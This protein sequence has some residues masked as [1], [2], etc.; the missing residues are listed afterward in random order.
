MKNSDHKNYKLVEKRYITEIKSDVYHFVHDQTNASI[1]Y[2]SNDDIDKFMSI[3]F[4]TPAED[5]S[6]KPHILE[7]LVLKKSKKY[8]TENLIV[9]VSEESLVNYA[10]AFTLPDRTVFPFSSSN[11]KE[12]INVMDFYLDC[13]FNP[14][15]YNEP[16]LFKKEVWRYIYNEKEDAL[17]VNGV[18]LSEMLGYLT[19]P[20]QYLY[21]QAANSL[22]RDT[23]MKYNYAGYPTE[24]I[25]LTNQDIINY[26]AKYY[27]PSNCCIVIYGN[28]DISTH[29][30]FIDENY[31][32]KFS[33]REVEKKVLQEHVFNEP[34][35][36]QH[37]YNIDEYDDKEF[38]SFY[39]I[40]FLLKNDNP[41][42]VAGMRVLKT[43][44]CDLPGS[45]V[46]KAFKEEYPECNISAELDYYSAQPFFSFSVSGMNENLH[47]EVYNL[48]VNVLRKSMAE[49]FEAN[50]IDSAI[51]AYE[52][53][54]RENQHSYFPK[55][56]VYTMNITN[57]IFI[58]KSPFDV[59]EYENV[60]SYLKAN[61]FSGLFQDLIKKHFLSIPHSCIVSAEPEFGVNVKLITEMKVYLEQ[62]KNSFDREKL[63]QFLPEASKYSNRQNDSLSKIYEI[64]L[65]DIEYEK[66]VLFSK[67]SDQDIRITTSEHITNKIVYVDF[68][69][70]I[71]D[72]SDEEMQR[73]VILTELVGKSHCDN[74]SSGMIYRLKNST[75]HFECLVEPFEDI[76][77]NSVRMFFKVKTKFLFSEMSKALKVISQLLKNIS[78]EDNEGWDNS[79]NTTEMQMNR[80]FLSH[81]H[82]ASLIRAGAYINKYFNMRDMVANVAL[83]RRCEQFSKER[84]KSIVLERANEVLRKILCRNRLS[85]VVTTDL[86]TAK[87]ITDHI[88]SA[89]LDFPNTVLWGSGKQDCCI[90]HNEAFIIPSHVQNFTY[91]VPLKLKDVESPGSIMLFNKIVRNL[92][93]DYNRSEGGGYGVF[94]SIN[95]SGDLLIT[96]YRDPDYLKTIHYIQTIL[97]VFESKN[98]DNKHLLSQKLN[99]LGKMNQ[100]LSPDHFHNRNVRRVHSGYNHEYITDL[101]DSIKKVEIDTIGRIM[102]KFD[103]VLGNAKYCVFGDEKAFAGKASMFQS[104]ERLIRR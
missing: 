53:E 85:V 14:A 91:C 39:A 12:F 49:G 10:Q 60:I 23:N 54:L 46:Q 100:P 52:F 75:G 93:L 26:H 69:F 37:K 55:G 11:D 68:S 33:F 96:S 83:Y 2:I 8:R 43:I 98:F 16:E 81:T 97:K 34:C 78:I 95:M 9:K 59:F 99:I 35:I 6:G 1:V 17:E 90:M 41:I 19:N 42:D 76:N 82:S 104:V 71:T 15:F 89:F 58:N 72:F 18:V 65:S 57:R 44:L 62:I 36:K 74:E 102:N 38:R 30:S 56:S 21:I 5:D 25:K 67:I 28:G 22:F 87:T 63:M 86:G 64:K 32:S 92:M 45:P 29:L 20:E 13:I 51:H 7:H 50:I 73:A 47:M 101:S 70:D 77:D 48:L 4:N 80:V 61:K 88:L 103:R 79:L 66:E 84:E 94:S 40:D 24:I 27:H 31:L 3:S